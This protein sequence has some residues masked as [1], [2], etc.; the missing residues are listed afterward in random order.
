MQHFTGPIVFTLLFAVIMANPL[1]AQSRAEELALI[2]RPFETDQVTLSPDGRH[3]AYTERSGENLDLVIRDLDANKLVRVPV[4]EARALE[5]SGAKEKTPARL[6]FLQWATTERLVFNLNDRNIWSIKAD[7]SGAKRL[8][9]PTEFAPPPEFV[10]PLPTGEFAATAGADAPGIPRPILDTLQPVDQ[11]VRVI[12][13]PRGDKYVFVEAQMRDRGHDLRPQSTNTGGGGSSFGYSANSNGNPRGVLRVD[14]NNG[15]IKDWGEAETRADYLLADQQGRPRVSRVSAGLRALESQFTYLD[16]KGG[17]WQPLDRLPAA[18]G[19]I[20]Q[21]DP[22]LRLGARSVPLAFDYDPNVLYFASNVG[23]DTYGIY[24]LDLK[25]QRRTDVAVETP[26]ADFIDPTAAHPSPLVFDQARRSLVGVRYTGAERAT[27]W[28]DPELAEVQDT[29]KRALPG[30]TAEI[31]EWDDARTRYLAFASS[32][33]DPGTYYLFHREDNRLDEI[34]ARAPWLPDFARNRSISFG[35]VSPQGVPL[36]GYLTLP[37]R[38]RLKRAPLVAL[39]HD[40]PWSRDLPGYNRWVQA[41]ASMGFAVVQV[42]YRGSTGFGQKHLHAL[43]EGP[44]TVA[45]ADITAAVD[46]VLKSNTVHPKLIALMGEGYGGY[47]ALRGLQLHPDKFR[48]AVAVNAPTDLAAWVNPATEAEAGLGLAVSAPSEHAFLPSGGE[49]LERRSNSMER[50]PTLSPDDDP[51]NVGVLGRDA[52]HGRIFTAELRQA[53][54]G[55]DLARLRKISPINQ[56]ELVRNPIMV[57]QSDRAATFGGRPFAEAVERNRIT[58]VF[59]GLS[60]DEAADLPLARAALFQQVEGFLNEHIYNYS[61]KLGETVILP[62]SPF[63]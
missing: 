8:A 40:G 17:K 59:L 52:P 23:R 38:P 16:A 43:R 41:L 22:K 32:H 58:A 47:L 18:A 35:F 28:L 55:S 25:N 11:P 12:T 51:R 44:D 21:F 24:A 46:W 26:S 14:V 45:L 1:P 2:F 49:S 63:P 31:L 33:S 53:F 15:R 30:R 20:F 37:Q 4:G 29:L 39:C 19:L 60:Q 13:L 9:D 42:N 50:N 10:G 48:C 36:T 3:L 57:I 34:M 54:F 6:T 62:E 61:V 5:L 7:G 56:P 27:A